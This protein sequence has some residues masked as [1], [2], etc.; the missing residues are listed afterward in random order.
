[1]LFWISHIALCVLPKTYTKKVCTSP[2]SANWT[3][4]KTIK[5]C[6]TLR[7]FWSLSGSQQTCEYI[8]RPNKTT[9]S[10]IKWMIFSSSCCE[11]DA[12]AA[13]GLHNGKKWIISRCNFVQLKGALFLNIDVNVSFTEMARSTPGFS[14]THAREL[15]SAAWPLKQICTADISTNFHRIISTFVSKRPT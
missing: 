2:S 9:T 13:I 5:F 4:H 11:V 15:I 8:Y 1:M 6:V 7:A 3:N 14:K 12:K 10:Y